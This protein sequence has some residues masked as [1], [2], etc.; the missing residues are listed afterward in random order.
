M[1]VCKGWVP[2]CDVLADDNGKEQNAA[3]GLVPRSGP[4]RVVKGALALAVLSAAHR[5]LV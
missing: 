5:L 3:E 1:R 2:P 4:G